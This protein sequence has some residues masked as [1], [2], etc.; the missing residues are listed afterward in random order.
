MR[1]GAV[2]LA[3]VLAA[4]AAAREAAPAKTPSFDV[5]IRGGTV[6]DGDGGAPR[7][8]DVG[9]VGDKVTAVG[10]LGKA[11]ARAVI[12]ARGLAVSP[13]FINML[14]WSTESLIADGRSQSEIRQGVTTEVF[15]EGASMGPYNEAMK[16]RETEEQADIKYDITWTTLH[17]YLAFLEKKGVSPNVAS[18]IGAATVREHVVGLASRGASPAEIEAMRE[19]VREEMEAGAL[20]I[21]S[22]LIYAPGTFANT[23]ELIELCKEAAKY[24]GKYITH[25]RS[26][27]DRLLESVDEVIRISREAGI[28]AEIYHLKAAGQT[29]WPKMDAVIE[30]IEAARRE[31]LKITADMYTYTA[32]STGFDACVSPWARAGGYDALFRRL[33]D[34]PTRTRI[35]QEMTGEGGPMLPWENLCAAAGSPDRIL[36]VGFKSDVL[37]PLTGK[38]LAEVAK[39]RN[40]D[41]WDT[42]LDLILEDR[43]RIGVV[44][45]LM[46]EDNVR[47]QLERP[48]VSFGSDAASMAP[49]GV[50]LKSS[51]HPRAYGNFARWLG[52]YVRDE[53]LVPLPEA[54]RRLSA[55]PATNLGLEGR[56]FLK[57]GMYADVV[58]FDPA[59]IADRATYESPQQ[60][61]VGVRHVLVNG[62]PVLKDGEHT[63]ALP[64]RALK[65][66]GALSAR[67]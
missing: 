66:P 60:Y 67:P 7:R 5:L 47:K 23:E 64:G 36:L 48:W 54:I 29:N 63:G 35:R 61:A 59:T 34:P 22:S 13:G 6:Y 20:G 32:G 14:S 62:V 21:G 27:A 57:P 8:A 41:P 1:V 9:I 55:L 25:M 49:E 52:H 11:R 65:G 15:G 18:F 19:L 38:T 39:M 56:G 17:E 53:K 4:P 51:T 46:S 50:F 30:K 31:G 24:K 2:L 28:P 37:K 40:K 12:D 45:F 33:Q 58:V 43:T 3:V 16:K 44:F 26:E 42:V 10:P